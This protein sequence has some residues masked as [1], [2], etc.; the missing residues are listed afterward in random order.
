MAGEGY[1]GVL[2]LLAWSHVLE[3][4]EDKFW[5]CFNLANLIGDRS[6]YILWGIFIEIPKVTS[7]RFSLVDILEINFKQV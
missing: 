5:K 4:K 6:R 3:A 2:Y 1:D 7:V